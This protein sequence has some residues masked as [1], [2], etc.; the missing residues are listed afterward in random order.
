MVRSLETVQR[1][2]YT[3]VTCET[4]SE[5]GN[6]FGEGLAR[7][8]N[9]N[10]EESGDPVIINQMSFLFCWMNHSHLRK[11]QEREPNTADEITPTAKVN[12]AWKPPPPTNAAAHIAAA[13]KATLVGLYA[14][15]SHC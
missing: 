4:R 1:F 3:F 13:A 14:H 8:E 12:G 9:R 5:R 7:P 6:Q 15:F 10:L 11:M 2:F